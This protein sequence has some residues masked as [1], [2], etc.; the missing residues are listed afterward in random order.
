MYY[1]ANHP[2][3]TIGSS[4]VKEPCHHSPKCYSIISHFHMIQ[5]FFYGFGHPFLQTWTNSL[6]NSVKIPIRDYAHTFPRVYAS[7][8][9][10]FRVCH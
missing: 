9:A 10:L 5:D 8:A 3:I 1:I 7:P 6:K 2:K 4:L